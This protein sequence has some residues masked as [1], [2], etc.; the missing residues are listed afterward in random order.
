[1]HRA[2]AKYGFTAISAGMYNSLG[3]QATDPS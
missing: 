2:V 3:L 1:M